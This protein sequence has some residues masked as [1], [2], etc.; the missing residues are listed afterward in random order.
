MVKIENK[1]IYD[2]MHG[3]NKSELQTIIHESKKGSLYANIHSMLQKTRPSRDQVIDNFSKHAFY[4]KN[5]MK[6]MSNAM[7]K[8]KIAG[9][10]EK[11]AEWVM[12][13]L[14]EN[15]S[16]S[17]KGL[18]KAI[19][20]IETKLMTNHGIQ[21]EDLGTLKVLKN[22]GFVGELTGYK[23]LFFE[24]LTKKYAI[25]Q[26]ANKIDELAKKPLPVSNQV[27]YIGKEVAGK[28]TQ[29]LA[30]KVG[31][32]AHSTINATKDYHTLAKYVAIA[33]LLIYGTGT[34]TKTLKGVGQR[35]LS[36]FSR[37]KRDYETFNRRYMH[38]HRSREHEYTTPGSGSGSWSGTGS[39]SWSGTAGSGTGSGPVHGIDSIHWDPQPKVV[40]YAPTLPGTSRKPMFSIR[41]ATPQQQPARPKPKP[42]EDSMTVPQ[43]KA[44]CKT[45]DIPITGLTRKS[46]IERRIREFRE[47]PGRRMAAV[48]KP[49]KKPATRRAP[50]KKP[51]EENENEND[52]NESGS[53]SNW[54][55]GK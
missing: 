38:R 42:R 11:F 35:I 6:M 19:R 30:D 27:V 40:R 13:L 1:H 37:K 20:D 22:E 51:A 17:V 52:Y 43:L 5:S 29:N 9:T 48:K 7:K 32:V 3:H 45:H 2:F 18:S 49:V 25:Q 23:K 31:S 41:W 50:V 21:V 15:T 34:V 12:I 4:T 28:L 54:V 10:P 24:T 16:K 8:G 47:N 36:I 46:N 26:V 44:Y 53:S 55:P 33:L 14:G 39:G